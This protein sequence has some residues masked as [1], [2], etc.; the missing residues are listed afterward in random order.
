MCA[1]GCVWL[2]L[3]IDYVIVTNKSVCSEI[4]SSA[5]S[6]LS[7]IL[8]VQRTEAFIALTNHL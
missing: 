8:G 2:L 1:N 3:F 6:D 7:Q 4:C 5:I